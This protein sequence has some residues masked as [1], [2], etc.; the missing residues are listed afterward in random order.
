MIPRDRNPMSGDLY[1]SQFTSAGRHQDGDSH[2][3]TFRIEP[4]DSRPRSDMGFLQYAVPDHTITITKKGA[5]S[6][7][8]RRYLYT[9]AK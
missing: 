2:S 4:G 3:Y 6:F 8:I 5:R 1:V 7:P 9:S